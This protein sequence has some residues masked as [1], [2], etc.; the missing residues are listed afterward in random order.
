MVG[1]ATAIPKQS[2]RNQ[3]L[4]EPEIVSQTTYSDPTGWSKTGTVKKTVYKSQATEQ[5]EAALKPKGVP[6]NTAREQATIELIE[7]AP[8]PLMPVPKKQ[9]AKIEFIE[10][11]DPKTGEK[12]AYPTPEGKKIQDQQLVMNDPR[13][14]AEQ[15]FVSARQQQLDEYAD[16]ARQERW[17]LSPRRKTQRELTESMQDQPGKP[18]KSMGDIAREAQKEEMRR[19]R[20]QR[21]NLK[22]RRKPLSEKDPQVRKELARMEDPDA[23]P[24]AWVEQTATGH[25]RVYVGSPEEAAA[26]DPRTIEQIRESFEREV[27]I[28]D[29]KLQP[30]TTKLSRK[31]KNA[32]KRA[33]ETRERWRSRQRDPR[34]VQQEAIER[35]ERQKR[36]EDRA[37]RMDRVEKASTRKRIQ[38]E[39]RAEVAKGVVP[40]DL[41][42]GLRQT[43]TFEDIDMRAPRTMESA[44]V[45][46]FMDKPREIRVD[47]DDSVFNRPVYGPDLPAPLPGA[48]ELPYAEKFGPAQMTYEELL[49][50]E[51]T[52][53]YR[54]VT[55]KSPFTR[56]TSGGKFVL[57]EGKLG[58]TM[59]S[60]RST[61]VTPK[62]LRRLIASTSRK[63]SE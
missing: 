33:A 2:G 52:G 42:P 16:A 21:R 36:M 34:A 17:E 30:Q 11:V 47:F 6:Q 46:Q 15:S 32:R 39:Q 23:N 1:K 4:K 40:E 18:G 43:V 28:G 5:A 27:R 9:A 22:T 62:E 58:V 29:M 49:K 55:E 38:M 25:E 48:K 31:E 8:G 60:I 45:D 14:K 37:R 61:N 54:F 24:N 7:G 63:A 57:Q 35:L 50:V 56:R 26:R 19:T 13:S 10:K 44:A 51:A 53:Q 12:L 3:V 59:D 20:T 41:S